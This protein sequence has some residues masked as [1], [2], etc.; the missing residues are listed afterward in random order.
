MKLIWVMFLIGAVAYLSATRNRLYNQSPP[1]GHEVLY[2]FRG[3]EM[4][5]WH[6]GGRHET[7]WGYYP[8]GYYTEENPAAGEIVWDLRHGDHLELVRAARAS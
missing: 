1:N 8:P 7:G 2:H 6:P 4:I 3:H 5:F